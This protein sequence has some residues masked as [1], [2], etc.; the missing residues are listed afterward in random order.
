MQL[1]TTSIYERRCVF[2]LVGFIKAVEVPFIIHKL[3][4][5]FQHTRWDLQQL[6]AKKRRKKQQENSLHI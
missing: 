1:N 5:V 4:L 2:Y 3:Y 6:A